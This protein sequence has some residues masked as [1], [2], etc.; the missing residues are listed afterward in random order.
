MTGRAKRAY[1]MN[2]KRNLFLA[3]KRNWSAYPKAVNKY[4]GSRIYMCG[5]LR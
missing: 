5:L 4:S 3:V 1:K 2:I